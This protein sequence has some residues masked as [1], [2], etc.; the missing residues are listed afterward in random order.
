[1]W[2]PIIMKLT[3]PDI[4]TALDRDDIMRSFLIGKEFEDST[5]DISQ[6]SIEK[7]CS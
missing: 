7:E 1:M 5:I 6:N 4:E 2:V 3:E